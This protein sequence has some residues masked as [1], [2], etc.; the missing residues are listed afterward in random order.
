MSTDA[1]LDMFIQ[2]GP[3][4]LNFLCSRGTCRSDLALRCHEMVNESVLTFT[5]SLVST[6]KTI[7]WYFW[8]GI[9]SVGHMHYRPFEAH[10]CTV[11]KEQM[12]T[13]NSMGISLILQF[14]RRKQC[15]HWPRPPVKGKNWTKMQPGR[16]WIFRK[17]KNLPYYIICSFCIQHT[18]MVGVTTISKITAKNI[19]PVTLEFY[20]LVKWI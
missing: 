15:K 18:F 7:Y 16:E 5:G 2:R 3:I 20:E 17:K 4:K 9:N 11:C 8:S 19:R 13:W 14:S 10:N 1:K 12:Q 6:P